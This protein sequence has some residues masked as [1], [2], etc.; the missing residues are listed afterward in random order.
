MLE[1]RRF[2]IRSL[3]LEIPNIDI[4]GQDKPKGNQ[5]KNHVGK[6]RRVALHNKDSAKD[7]KTCPKYPGQTNYN[8]QASARWFRVCGDLLIGNGHSAS[9]SALPTSAELR[10]TYGK[11]P[12]RYGWRPDHPSFE[13]CATPY[14]LRT[15]QQYM[16]FRGSGQRANRKNLIPFKIKAACRSLRQLRRAE[17]KKCAEADVLRGGN[18]SPKQFHS[19]QVAGNAGSLRP[20]SGLGVARRF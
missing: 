5:P 9:I 17:L 13:T 20:A 18:C 16:R 10:A 15:R 12:E 3:A 7:Q 4:T 2:V 8:R 11:C 19:P 14:A 6:T 1:C